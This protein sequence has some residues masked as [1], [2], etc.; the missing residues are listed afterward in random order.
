MAFLAGRIAIRDLPGH[1]D[2]QQ[3][4]NPKNHKNP[5]KPIS[6]TGPIDQLCGWAHDGVSGV[7][8]PLSRLLGCIWRNGGAS[9]SNSVIW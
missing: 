1:R 4:R 8:R 2:R 7:A 3:P 6:H 9:V 5:K